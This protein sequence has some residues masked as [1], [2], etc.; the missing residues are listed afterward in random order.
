MAHLHLN[1][2]CDRDMRASVANDIPG[3]RLAT[4]WVTRSAGPN[5]CNRVVLPS[6]GV[7]KG[8]VGPVHAVPRVGRR[9]ND[10]VWIADAMIVD[11]RAERPAELPARIIGALESRSRQTA[12]AQ[13]HQLILRTEVR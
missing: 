2:N 7:N 10:A 8:D 1:E 3:F 9:T 13:R 12:E 6:S 4:V 5:L 11:Q